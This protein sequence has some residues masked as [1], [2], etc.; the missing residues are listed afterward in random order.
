MVQ[1][2]ESAEELL[3]AA[4]LV[5]DNHTTFAASLD[6]KDFD[7]RTITALDSTHHT[8]VDLERIRARLLEE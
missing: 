8:L 5:A 6:L 2:R 3:R 4:H 7:N 1:V